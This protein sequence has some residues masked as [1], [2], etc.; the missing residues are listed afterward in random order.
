MRLVTVRSQL[1]SLSCSVK[2]LGQTIDKKLFITT[3]RAGQTID[4]TLLITAAVET[5]LSTIN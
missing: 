1:C 2:H 4:K 5:Q 3:A